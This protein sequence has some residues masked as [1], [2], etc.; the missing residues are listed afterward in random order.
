MSSF[1]VKATSWVGFAPPVIP[2]G[3]GKSILGQLSWVGFE[4]VG[5]FLGAR[6]EIFKLDYE[7]T[8][9]QEHEDYASTTRRDRE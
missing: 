5:W 9:R 1:V 8:T 4:L 7:S 2:L 3:A 6:I